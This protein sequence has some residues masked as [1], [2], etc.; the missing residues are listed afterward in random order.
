MT[1][2]HVVEFSAVDPFVEAISKSNCRSMLPEFGRRARLIPPDWPV[3]AAMP[4]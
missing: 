3:C 2:R 4:Q 1:Y